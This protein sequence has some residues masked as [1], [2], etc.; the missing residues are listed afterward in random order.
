MDSLKLR[1]TLTMMYF[2][3]CKEHATSFL[4]ILWIQFSTLCSSQFDFCITVSTH[5][6]I[7]ELTQHRLDLG[8]K[9]TTRR[10]LRCTVNA[11]THAYP[12]QNCLKRLRKLL[13]NKASSTPTYLLKH[14]YVQMYTHRYNTCIHTYIHRY[15]LP[16][17]RMVENPNTAICEWFTPTYY[18]KHMYVHVHT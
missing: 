18:M 3:P 2:N 5:A 17:A 8:D 13:K 7:K 6:Q 10:M 1:S 11:Y 12:K 9:P 16:C 14:M 15:I 4:L